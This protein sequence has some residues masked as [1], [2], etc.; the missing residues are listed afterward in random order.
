MVSILDSV[1]EESPLLDDVN[2]YVVEERHSSTTEQELVESKADE[3]VI[4]ILSVLLIG[5]H[6]KSL[7]F[8]PLLTIFT[9]VFISQADV[10]LVL[11]T[12]GSI[13][14][15]FNALDDGDWLL[16]SYLLAQSVAQ[17]LV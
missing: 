8:R 9:A 2:H 10:F 16:T 14:S 5:K 6:L 15:E 13:A 1:G 12:Y 17:P 7:L 11:T 4:G 3:P